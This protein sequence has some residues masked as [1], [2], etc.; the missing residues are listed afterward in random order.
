MLD[1]YNFPAASLS[2]SHQRIMKEA[3]DQLHK[4]NLLL[5]EEIEEHK[6]VLAVH[7]KVIEDLVK[8]TKEGVG[9]VRENS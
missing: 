3:L 7:K 1:Q 5:R 8:E 2:R 4:E 9:L 6:G